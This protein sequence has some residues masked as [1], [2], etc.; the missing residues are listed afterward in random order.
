MDPPQ[1]ILCQRVNFDQRL[2]SP[3]AWKHAQQSYCCSEG[4]V[5][6]VSRMRGCDRIGPSFGAC[7]LLLLAHTN[8]PSLP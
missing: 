5:L 4:V 7:W 1:S 8:L 6:T 2:P 3:N